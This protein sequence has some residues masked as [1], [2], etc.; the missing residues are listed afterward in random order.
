MEEIQNCLYGLSTV[1]L[2]HS[3]WMELNASRSQASDAKSFSVFPMFYQDTTKQVVWD[4][5]WRPGGIIK[6]NGQ[7]GMV[8]IIN[9]NLA[10]AA[11]TD[12]ALIQKDLDQLW[13][14][15]P[16]QEGTSD[17]RFIPDTASG[18]NSIISQNDMPLNDIIDTA[19]D[20]ELKPFIEMLYERNLRFKD[21]SELLSVWDEADLAEAG[22]QIDQD[23]KPSIDIKDL[24]INLNVK[25]LGTLELSNEVA[26]QQGW[27]A[28]GNVATTI[29]PLASRVDW[30]EYGDKLLRSY[31][32]KDDASN[33]WIDE[34][35]Y[36]K[37]QQEMQLSQ[38]QQQQSAM[39][40]AAQ[41]ENERV[42]R[43]VQEHQAKKAI[44]TESNIV[45][46]QSEALLEKSTGQKVQ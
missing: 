18:T 33:I 38:Q 17:R 42:G 1:V 28:F 2:G 41:M 21:V 31:G 27:S 36:Q 13:S 45:I 46:M 9:P 14:L 23:G 35:I 30:N 3:L 19:T 39:Q 10:N 4:K 15:S 26:H 29:P 37:A 12:S 25:L 40:Q 16:V 6:G 22:V 43:S 11:I 20:N 44:D 32:I 8:P 5:V 7:N 24:L 34:A